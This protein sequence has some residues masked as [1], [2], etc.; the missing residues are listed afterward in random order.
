MN[1]H[2]TIAEAEHLLTQGEL[3]KVANIAGYILKTKEFSIE[4][5][6]RQAVLDRIYRPAQ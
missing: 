3:T 5:D 6:G 1:G 2:E 4:T